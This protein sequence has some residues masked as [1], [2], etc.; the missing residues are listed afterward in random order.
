MVE[1]PSEVSFSMFFA[2]CASKTSF[3][4]TRIAVLPQHISSR[5]MMPKSSP[6]APSTRAVASATFCMLGR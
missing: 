4:P 2:A 6:A 3:M 1:T 5:P